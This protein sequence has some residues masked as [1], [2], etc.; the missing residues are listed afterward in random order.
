[1]ADF[2]PDAMI[3]RF[4]ERASSVKRRN[5]PPVEG[6]ARKDF[7][8]QAETDFRDFAMVADAAATIEDGVL[9]L[10]VDL[11]PQAARG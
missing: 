5:I 6:E 1:M 8:R 4:A 3:Q 11:R 9:I 2:D 10:R 7:I